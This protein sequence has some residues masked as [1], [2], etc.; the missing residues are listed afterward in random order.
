M[1]TQINSASGDSSAEGQLTPEQKS[2]LEELFLRGIAELG[3]PEQLTADSL[4]PVLQAG[5]D[6][7]AKFAQEMIDG[8]TERARIVR[9]VLCADVYGRCVHA[10]S[11]Q[12]ALDRAEDHT[13]DALVRRIR[14]E[15]GL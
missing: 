10:V 13:R 11:V 12:N 1:T 14:K 9:G 8:R 2:S 5:L 4:I 7:S 15:M 3:V 6:A